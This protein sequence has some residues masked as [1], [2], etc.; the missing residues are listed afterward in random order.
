M[1]IKIRKY[2]YFVGDSVL[3]IKHK[4]VM[5]KKI[6]A[7]YAFNTAFMFSGLKDI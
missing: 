4:P 2:A 7:T 1:V 5:G 3:E 6:A